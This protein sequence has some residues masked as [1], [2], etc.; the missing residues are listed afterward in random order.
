MLVSCCYIWLLEST[1]VY[2]FGVCVCARVCVCVCVRTCVCAW[3]VCVCIC[4]CILCM[5]VYLCVCVF[6]CVCAH[7]HIHVCMNTSL[8]SKTQSLFHK[9]CLN[10][11]TYIEIYIHEK[12]DDISC[13]IPSVKDTAK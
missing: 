5:C 8:L 13:K 10:R 4:V 11:Y 2:D 3:R 12:T 9:A 1:L 6:V 7:A